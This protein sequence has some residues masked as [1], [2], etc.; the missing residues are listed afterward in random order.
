MD[1]R[2]IINGLPFEWD[3]DK[4][5]INIRKHKVSFDEA[6]LVFFDDTLWEYYDFKHSVSENRR[7]AIGRVNNILFVVY[8]RR[9]NN[10]LRLIS[11]RPATKSEKRRYYGRL[12]N[13]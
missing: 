6:A 1:I 7:I 5:K 12:R 11:A 3:E 4:E 8:T 9:E 2:K 10:V 13:R